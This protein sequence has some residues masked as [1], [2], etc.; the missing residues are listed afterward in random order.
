MICRIMKK[1]RKRKKNR[2]KREK[3]TLA[4]KLK[5]SLKSK[6]VWDMVIKISGKHQITQIKHIFQNNDTITDKKEISRYS[7]RN[8]LK[9]IP[10]VKHG[11]QKFL[12]LK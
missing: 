1:E 4:N 3:R 2:K 10:Q 12:V 5:N 8:L 7:Y 11:R 6:T 9:I